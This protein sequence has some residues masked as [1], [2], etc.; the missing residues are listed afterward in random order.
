MKKQKWMITLA[1][2]MIASFSTVAQADQM[3]SS[4]SQADCSALTSAEQDFASKLN[5]A[6][7]QL[8]CGKFAAAQRAQAMQMAATP[9]MNGNNVTPDQAVTSVNGGVQAIPS[10][11][12]GCPV[13]K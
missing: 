7:Q 10:S 11:S 6:N 5:P 13:T 1:L 12:G 4:N 2:G 3:S 8:F 9:D